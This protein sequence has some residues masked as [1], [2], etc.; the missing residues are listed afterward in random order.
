MIGPIFTRKET[1]PARDLSLLQKSSARL[2]YSGPRTWL[3]SS[4]SCA[5]RG[6][7]ACVRWPRVSMPEAFLP[8]R[9]GDG[10]WYR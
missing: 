3:L 5:L 6:Q 10:L 9:V 7:K 1:W 4:V 2:P 8:R